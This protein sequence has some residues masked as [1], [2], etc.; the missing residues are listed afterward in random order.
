MRHP[1]ALDPAVHLQFFMLRCAEGKNPFVASR[2]VRI[3]QPKS[4]RIFLFAV[5]HLFLSGPQIKFNMDSTPKAVSQQPLREHSNGSTGIFP[6]LTDGYIAGC[7]KPETE[8]KTYNIN[9]EFSDIDDAPSQGSLSSADFP[10][11]SRVIAAWA[12]TLSK[13]IGADEVSFWV[14]VHNGSQWHPSVCHL[15]V[16]ETQTQSQLLQQTRDF[17][18]R[19]WHERLKSTFKPRN[20]EPFSQ[21]AN[22]AVVFHGEPS[23]SSDTVLDQPFQVFINRFWLLISFPC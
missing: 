19:V 7:T 14:F 15:T 3:F 23:S 13:Y 9:L 16:H 1:F 10:S 5:L 12:L 18:R 4:L 20:S 2:P 17:L 22:T 8:G 6:S 21:P 11:E